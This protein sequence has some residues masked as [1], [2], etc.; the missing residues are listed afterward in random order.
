MAKTLAPTLK[1]HERI[2]VGL[3]TPDIDK[4]ARLAKALVGAV[5]GVKNGQERDRKSAV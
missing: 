2:F 4:A 5:G 3:D 1:P